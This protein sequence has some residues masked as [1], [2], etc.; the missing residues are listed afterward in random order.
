MA[1]YSIRALADLSKEA[2]GF[3]TQAIPGAV[4]SVWPNTFTVIAKVL[5]LL[6]FEH[7]LR[8]KWLFKQTFASTADELW[9]ARHGFELGMTRGAGSA[10][11]GAIVVPVQPGVLLPT[12][13][14]FVRGDG[15][16]FTT[17]AGAYTVGAS[18]ELYVVADAIGALGNTPAGTTLALI[19]PQ[20]APAGMDATAVVEADAIGAG[21]DPEPLEAFRARVLARKRNPPQGGSALDY[22]AWAFEAIEG[23]VTAVYV[24]SFENDSRSVWVQFTVGDQ[25]GGIPSPAQVQVVQD[26]LNDPV[27][28]PV[29]ARVF[30]SAPVPVLVPVTIQG[31]SPDTSDIRTSIAAE[32]AATFLD[33]AQPGTPSRAFRLSRS[34]LDEAISRATGE[35]GHVTLAPPSDLI[36]GAGQYPSLG[37]IS[38]T[39]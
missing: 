34:W 9:L 16:T 36:F 29:T 6:N 30:V 18:V 2:R 31:L 35:E 17:L 19:D 21:S 7:E 8:R 33:R 5:A 25:P 4:A 3:F 39:D 26:Y 32:L 24:D 1:G 20:N 22:Q 11:L 28:R 38:Y 23:A 15:A 27:R 10:A 12:G 14:Q 37:P 13:L